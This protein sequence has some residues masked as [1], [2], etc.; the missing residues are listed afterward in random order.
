LGDAGRRMVEQNRG[1][2]VR[3]VTLIEKVLG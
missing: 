3:T 2:L 1:A